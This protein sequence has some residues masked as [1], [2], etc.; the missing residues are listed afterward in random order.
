MAIWDHT[1]S[2][3]KTV[4]FLS[5]IG[6]GP[7]WFAEYWDYTRMHFARGP[8]VM[9]EGLELLEELVDRHNEVEVYIIRV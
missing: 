5:L 8:H 3:L 2:F 6:R 7:G 1:I 9:P 4:G